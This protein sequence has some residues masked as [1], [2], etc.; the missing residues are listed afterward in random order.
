MTT[1]EYLKIPRERVGVLIGKKGEVKQHIE[2]LTQTT[3]DIDSE[4]G[5]VTIIPQEDLEDPLLPWKT[6][7]IVKA[8]GRGFNPEIA[9]RLLK[10]DVALD[11][12]KLTEYVGKSKKALARQKGRIIGR[13][14]ITR[15]IIHEMTGVDMSVYGK[16]VSIIGD[17]E[18]LLIAKEAVEMILNGSRHKSVY[19]FLE[20]KKQDM[21]LKHFHDTIN[22]K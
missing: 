2:K 6:R 13:D 12:I 4:A 3:L 8:I 9:L 20:K 16:T 19:G 14:G 11:I 1:T 15:Q 22:L 17:L 21:K 18:N 10:D 5:T 7:S